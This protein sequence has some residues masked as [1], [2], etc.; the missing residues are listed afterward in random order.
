M[1]KRTEPTELTESQRESMIVFLFFMV[2]VGGLSALVGGIWTLVLAARLTISW[3]HLFLLIAGLLWTVVFGDILE[4][5]FDEE[6]A[7]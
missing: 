6:E 3:P 5:Q 2:G 1:S 4:R 7:E